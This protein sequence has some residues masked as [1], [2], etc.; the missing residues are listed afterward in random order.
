METLKNSLRKTGWIA[1][2]GASALIACCCIMWS[3]TA[4][5]D[6]LPGL[7]IQ[8]LAGN[9]MQ[10]TVTNGASTNSYEIYRRLAFDPLYPWTPH[11]MGTTGQTNFTAAMGIDT[12]GFFQ[13][14]AGNDSD[15]DGVLNSQDGDPNNQA[16]GILSIFID[17]PASGST[18][19]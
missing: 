15:G 3:N 9:Q 13:A 18:I 1:G 19:Q 2:T 17:S 7:T 11:L 5:S 6:D 4:K 14:R 10:L 16:V 8:L 12:V